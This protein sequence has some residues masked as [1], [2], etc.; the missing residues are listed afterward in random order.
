[1]DKHDDPKTKFC[2]HIFNFKCF[3]P[4]KIE[5]MILA[6]KSPKKGLIIKVD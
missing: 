3:P 2:L 6:L 1:M 5:E 4:F